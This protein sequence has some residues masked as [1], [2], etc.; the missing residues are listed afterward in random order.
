ASAGALKQ[1]PGN[2]K[3]LTIL[4]LAF[5]SPVK[6]LEL[7]IDAL[8]L[9]NDFAVEW[10]HIGDGDEYAVHVKNYAREK[11]S[12][13]RNIS[14]FFHGTMNKAE[15]TDFLRNQDIDMIVNTSFS[16]GLPVSLMEAMAF[17]IPAVA[18]RVGG[19]PEIIEHGKNGF[20]LSSSPSAGELSETLTAYWKSDTGAKN[21]LKMQAYKTWEDKFNAET[22]YRKF[23]EDILSL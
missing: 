20:L 8:S 3:S 17:S 5:I 2:R 21:F 9:I 10:H 6:H 18:P 16:E 7:L 1:Y 13:K 12:Y 19:I 23:A 14:Y 4:S 11:L 15:I 22:N